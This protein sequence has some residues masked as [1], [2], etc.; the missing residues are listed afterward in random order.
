[1][2][3]C[4]EWST[5]IKFHFDTDNVYFVQQTEESISEQ[6]LHFVYN[7]QSHSNVTCQY[8]M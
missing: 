8:Q 4:A 2:S 1:M 7:H 5:S 3:R 6:T